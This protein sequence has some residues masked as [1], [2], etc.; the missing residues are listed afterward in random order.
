M[1]VIRFGSPIFHVRDEIKSS[2]AG[3]EADGVS[4]RETYDFIRFQ[5]N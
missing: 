3:Y 4:E 5:V 2:R 1:N